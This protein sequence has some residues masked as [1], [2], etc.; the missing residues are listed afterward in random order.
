M[1][2][3]LSKNLINIVN[4]LSDG[5]Y[6]D[7]NTMGNQLSMTRSAVWKTIKKLQGYDL[8][9]Q[10]VKG[11]GYVLLEPLTLLDIKEI[12]KN[13]NRKNIDIEI[14]GS[15]DSTNAY[16]KK[17]KQV[18]TTKI[19]LAEQ[20]T[21]GKGRL[22]RDW[23]SPF[24]KNIYLSC[25][26]VFQKDISE[27][28]GLSLVTSL[29]ILNGL[30][31]FDVKQCNVKWPNDIMYE[32]RKLAGIL[33]EIQAETHGS[34]QAIIGIG[35]NVNMLEDQHSISQTWTSVQAIQK[36][37]IDRNELCAALINELLVY[38]DKFDDKGFNQFVSE[39]VQT[40]CLTNQIITVK[41]S[42]DKI[43]GKVLGINDRGHLL[44]ELINGTVRGFSSGDTSIMKKE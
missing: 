18:K 41:N 42:N 13:L 15:I 19:C 39:W 21:Q 38:L 24:G 8:N 1:K 33:V 22:N 30:R 12:K 40:D 23:Y 36:K 25:L 44:L 17:F 31:K 3:K 2:T 27:L 43:Q 26:Y 16:L 11:K 20:Q 4:I 5:D 34:S 7:G 28:A 9:I 35:I 37:Y 10:S 14:F 6:H 29:A 32:Q